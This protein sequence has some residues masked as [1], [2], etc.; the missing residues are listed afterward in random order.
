M[1][2]SA[3]CEP[4]CSRLSGGW[5]ILKLAPVLG[6]FSVQALRDLTV[7]CGEGLVLNLCLH[8]DLERLQDKVQA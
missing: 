5:Q 3:L 4:D 8:R 2:R 6:T 1:P 7:G